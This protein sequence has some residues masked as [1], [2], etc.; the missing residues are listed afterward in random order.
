MFN[1]GERVRLLSNPLDE[2]LGEYIPIGVKTITDVDMFQE[3]LVNG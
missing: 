1:K 2:Q 3:P